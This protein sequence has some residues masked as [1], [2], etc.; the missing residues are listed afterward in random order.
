MTCLRWAQK[1]TIG[2][3]CLAVMQWCQ[4]HMGCWGGQAGIAWQKMC[5]FEIQPLTTPTCTTGLVTAS[6]SNAGLS[7]ADPDAVALLP[8]LLK[9][10]RDS[11]SVKT[12]CKSSAPRTYPKAHSHP[13]CRVLMAPINPP[14]GSTLPAAAV[15]ARLTA[16]MRKLDS[17]TVQKGNK[18]KLGV[19]FYNKRNLKLLYLIHLL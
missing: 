5:R 10:T 11:R 18:S 9:A 2:C 12:I 3:V 8:L 19:R 17:S 6:A 13:A 16:A 15:M 4:G 1:S 14:S 7:A